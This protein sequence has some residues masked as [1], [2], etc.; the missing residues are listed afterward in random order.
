MTKKHFIDL[1]KRIKWIKE[2]YKNNPE[3]LKIVLEM[4][5]ELVSFC[6]QHGSNFN[7]SRFI[8]ACELD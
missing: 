7:S 4:Q 6:Y 1:A 8:N 3:A 5:E 2:K